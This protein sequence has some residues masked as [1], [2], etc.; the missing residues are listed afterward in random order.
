MIDFAKTKGA[1]RFVFIRTGKNDEL[2]KLIEE[3]GL[4]F[5]DES[6]DFCM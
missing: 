4:V 1:R 5:T 3:S 2:F 6:Y